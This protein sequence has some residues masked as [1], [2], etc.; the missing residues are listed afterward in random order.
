MLAKVVCVAV[1]AGSFVA[2]MTPPR[3]AAAATTTN[4]KLKIQSEGRF[5][6]RFF[7]DWLPTLIIRLTLFLVMTYTG[8]LLWIYHTAA[9]GR[10][11]CVN[12]NDVQEYQVWRQL[13]VLKSWHPMVCA[14]AIFGGWLRRWSFATLDRFFTYRLTIHADHKL[15]STGPYKYLRHPSYTGALLAVSGAYLLLLHQGLWPIFTALLSGWT[16][17]YLIPASP[18]V[19]PVLTVL[20]GAIPVWGQLTGPNGGAW[21][22]AALTAFY[23]EMFRRRIKGEEA[24]L[25]Q[26]F[27]KEW[28]LYASQRWRFIPLLF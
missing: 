4:R 11:G 5:L 25:K 9:T 13:L 27:G 17:S 23:V 2:S 14:M 16:R 22:T 21:V 20:Q 15:V 12:C 3:A 1:G 10:D 24:M 6:D 19:P 8:C 7:V 26:H 28:D 18:M